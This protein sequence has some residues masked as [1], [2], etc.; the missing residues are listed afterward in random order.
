MGKIK[1]STD[2][3]KLK[4]LLLNTTNF[5]QKSKH[6]KM[7]KYYAAINNR[8]DEMSQTHTILILSFVSPHCIKFNHSLRS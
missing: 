3:L 7:V 1:E 4:R 6:K 8:H 2:L 5:V